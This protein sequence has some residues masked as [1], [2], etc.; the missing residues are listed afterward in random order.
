MASKVRPSAPYDQC[1]DGVQDSLNYK[2]STRFCIPLPGQT[3]ETEDM[4]LAESVCC[5]S[6]NLP[7]AEPQFLFEAPDVN[8]FNSLDKTKVTTFYLL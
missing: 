8:L 4:P 5:D 2:I 6:R 1:K 7:F 3:C